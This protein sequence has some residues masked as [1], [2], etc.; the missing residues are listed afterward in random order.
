MMMFAVKQIWAE[1]LR[2]LRHKVR[3]MF[4]LKLHCHSY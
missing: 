4:I 2:Q 1:K 3:S